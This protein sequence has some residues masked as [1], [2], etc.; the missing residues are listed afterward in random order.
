MASSGIGNDAKPPIFRG[1]S[2]NRWTYW[3]GGA[4]RRASGLVAGSGCSGG[5]EPLPNSLSFSRENARLRIAIGNFRSY[6]SQEGEGH[7]LTKE[8]CK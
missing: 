2:S 8:H 3:D 5:S 4:W 7:M 6:P 1:R